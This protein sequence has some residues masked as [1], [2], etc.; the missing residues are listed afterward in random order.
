MGGHAG[1]PG[2]GSSNGQK[3]DFCRRQHLIKSL[4]ILEGYGR[5]LVQGRERSMQWTRSGRK[6]MVL[7][8][9]KKNQ[10][11]KNRKRK[12]LWLD[13]GSASSSLLL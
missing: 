5:C 11:A 4:L 7:E 9:L 6:R 12:G 3:E 10:K 8:E 1:S 2:P 13:S